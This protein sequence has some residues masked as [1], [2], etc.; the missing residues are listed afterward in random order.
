[1][2]HEKRNFQ[3]CQRSENA[4]VM[5]GWSIGE[6]I[7]FAEALEENEGRMGE[8]AAHSVTMNQYGLKDY[9]EYAAVIASLPEGNWWQTPTR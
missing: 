5:I 2:L 1:M 7:A 3:D 4:K 6:C 8:Q 9:D